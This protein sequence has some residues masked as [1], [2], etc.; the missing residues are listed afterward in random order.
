MKIT[1]ITAYAVQL[2]LKEASYSWNT[3]SYAAFDS[4]VVVTPLWDVLGDP[5]FAIT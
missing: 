2:P 5:I 1:G 3:Q 4:T